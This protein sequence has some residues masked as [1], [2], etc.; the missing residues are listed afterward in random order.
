MLSVFAVAISLAF[1]T[2]NVVKAAIGGRLPHRMAVIRRRH[3]AEWSREHL[4][5]SFKRKRRSLEPRLYEPTVSVARRPDFQARDNSSGLCSHAGIGLGGDPCTDRTPRQFGPLA[6]SGNSQVRKSAWWA[7][8]DSNLQPDR[9]ERSALTIELRAPEAWGRPG[10]LHLH[11]MPD[12]ERQ[13]D[14]GARVA[15]SLR[16]PPVMAG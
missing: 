14:R 4:V 13:R 2:P 1:L 10:P 16:C 11:T 5:P 7:R 9:Y 3:P 15:C 12:R 8:E 6:Q